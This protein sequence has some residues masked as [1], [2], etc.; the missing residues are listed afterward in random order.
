VFVANAIFAKISM[1]NTIWCEITGVIFAILVAGV[2]YT[3]VDR[4][5]LA[6]RS[7]FFSVQLGIALGIG[8]FVLLAIGL[9]GGILV[10]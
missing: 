7:K 10:L 1:R 6:Y 2:L 8:A 4:N 5:I 9:L 3:L